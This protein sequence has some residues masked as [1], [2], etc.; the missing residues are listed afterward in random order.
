MIQSKESLKPKYSNV[1]RKEW[2]EIDVQKKILFEGRKIV[3][4]LTEIVVIL[5]QEQENR[6]GDKNA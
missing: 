6:K 1:N 2:T 4:L 5:K 3:D